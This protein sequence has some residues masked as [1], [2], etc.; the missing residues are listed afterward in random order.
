MAQFQANGDLILT[1]SFGTFRYKAG[2]VTNYERIVSK[3]PNSFTRLPDPVEEIPAVE[4][5][6]EEIKTNEVPSKGK[7]EKTNEQF[8][9]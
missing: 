6:V 9:S 3:F 5:V 7:K 4:E 8:P 1:C 2:E